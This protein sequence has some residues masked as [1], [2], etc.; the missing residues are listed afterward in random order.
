M[1]VKITDNTA[2]VLSQYRK[3]LLKA[4][5]RCGM[6]A[7][8]F[9]VKEITK[10]KAVDTGLLRNSITFAVGGHPAN[11]ATYSADRGGGGGSYSGNASDDGTPRVY[12]GTNVEYAPYIEMGTGA[13]NVPGGTPKDSWVY[14]DAHGEFHRAFPQ[15]QDRF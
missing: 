8:G 4:M 11:K 7:E 14:M 6:A 9:A 2:N 15:N 13:A 1:G 3:A 10:L 12:I 5:T